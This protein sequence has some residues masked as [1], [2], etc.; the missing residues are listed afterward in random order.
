M[1]FL[2][3]LVSSYILRFTYFVDCFE[4]FFMFIAYINFI[5]LLCLFVVSLNVGPHYLY[6]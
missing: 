6:V 2:I 5:C 3:A 1:G 4:M